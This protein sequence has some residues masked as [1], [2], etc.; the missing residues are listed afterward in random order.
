[1]NAAVATASIAGPLLAVILRT[2]LAAADGTIP[3]VGAVSALSDQ[4]I[5][6]VDAV[7]SSDA[8][9]AEAKKRAVVM[10]DQARR[11]HSKA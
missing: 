9:L 11:F 6:Q 2:G 10:K 8:H 5:A 4:L 3:F 7:A 1:M